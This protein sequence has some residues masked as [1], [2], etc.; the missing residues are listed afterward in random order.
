[1]TLSLKWQSSQSM[2]Q[3]TKSHYFQAF[4]KMYLL[5][6]ENRSKKI[7]ILRHGTMRVALHE[8]ILSLLVGLLWWEK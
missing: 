4:R 3:F 5:L 6:V 2:C 8:V 7:N 1:M